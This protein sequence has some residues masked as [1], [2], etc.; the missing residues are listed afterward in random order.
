[1]RRIIFAALFFAFS[2]AA[3]DGEELLLR[4]L[5]ESPEAKITFRQKS[6]DE[7]GNEISEVRG[8]FWYR[9]P[10]LFRMEY[11]PPDEL[12]VVS[13]GEKNWTFQPELNQVLVQPADSLSGASAILD[14]LAS[15]DLSPLA[16]KYIFF[17]GLGG[18]LRWFNAEARTHASDQSIRRWRMGF[19][20]DGVLRR[21]ELRDSFGNSAELEV[22]LVSRKPA[23][24]ALFRF[25]PP[26]GADIIQE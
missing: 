9:R 5:Q 16:D 3:E 17:S 10:G 2:A 4:F 22:Y 24:D 23:D 13:D 8:H 25:T 6:L 15:G 20:P 18:E 21:V 26:V 19:S 12:L 7:G 14:M 1:M 11:E